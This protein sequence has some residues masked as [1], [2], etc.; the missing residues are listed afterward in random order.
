MFSFG[1]SEKRDLKRLLELKKEE[2]CSAA[3]ESCDDVRFRYLHGELGS[4]SM[5]PNPDGVA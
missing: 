2:K 4:R 3:R 5:P 1:N